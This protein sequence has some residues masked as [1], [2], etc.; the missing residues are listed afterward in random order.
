MRVSER[1][2]FEH[3]MRVTEARYNSDRR[4]WDYRLNNTDGRP[5]GRWV[6]ETNLE[7]LD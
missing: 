7:D 6:A 3:S 5:Y 4:G 2:F 1:D